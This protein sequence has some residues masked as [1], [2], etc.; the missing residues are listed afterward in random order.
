MLAEQSR[1]RQKDSG[2]S[3]LGFTGP[4]SECTPGLRYEESVTGQYDSES[5][6]EGYFEPRVLLQSLADFLLQE[7]M[8]DE[9]ALIGLLGEARELPTNRPLPIVG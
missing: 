6:I 9:R 3:V 5:Q 4:A 8:R 2:L 7:G 1:I